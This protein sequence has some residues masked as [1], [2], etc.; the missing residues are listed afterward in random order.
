MSDENDEDLVYLRRPANSQYFFT[1]RYDSQR[2]SA[3]LTYI[4]W[5][6]GNGKMGV[7]KI[8]KPEIRKPEPDPESEPEPETEWQL[9]QSG[10][11]CNQ[12]S[13]KIFLDIWVKMSFYY[14]DLRYYQD[15]VELGNWLEKSKWNFYCYS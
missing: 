6:L 15:I 12:F 9:C 1:Q 13:G 4:S 11:H 10:K 7:W 2:L 3:I 5:Y 8:Y 14:P